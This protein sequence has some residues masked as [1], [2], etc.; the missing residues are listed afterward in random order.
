MTA[1]ELGAGNVLAVGA[2]VV[3]A[4]A[5]CLPVR[6]RVWRSALGAGA[7]LEGSAVVGMGVISCRVERLVLPLLSRPAAPH[8]VQPRLENLGYSI[9]TTEALG[10]GRQCALPSN[11]YF[12]AGQRLQR[13]APLAD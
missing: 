10:H 13:R 3:A 4:E 6:G 11:A 8:I 7:A 12:E 9:A 5:R 1:G 2:A